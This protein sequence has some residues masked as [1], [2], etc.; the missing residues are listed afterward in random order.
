MKYHP[1]V[2][3]NR[4]HHAMRMCSLRY[5]EDSL[6]INAASIRGCYLEG[7]QWSEGRA[8]P[9]KREGHV[10]SISSAVFHPAIFS[11]ALP[12]TY[13]TFHFVMIFHPDTSH[14]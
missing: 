7:L 1:E 9:G 14:H 2:I 13:G 8:V 3:S 6:M 12:S 4:I 5:T 11:S 10:C